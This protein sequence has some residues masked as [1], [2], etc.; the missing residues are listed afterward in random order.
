M[1]IKEVVKMPTDFVEKL[2][3]GGVSKNSKTQSANVKPALERLEI[4]RQWLMM[5]KGLGLTKEEI[6]LNFDVVN[7]YIASFKELGCSNDQINQLLSNIISEN[8]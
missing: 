3:V 4:I 5:S 7:N 2:E 6:G 1:D 8:S